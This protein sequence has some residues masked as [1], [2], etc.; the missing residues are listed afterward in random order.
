MRAQK[1]EEKIK[2]FKCKGN[3]RHKKAGELQERAK[4]L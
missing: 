3:E 4:G 2:K 1:T